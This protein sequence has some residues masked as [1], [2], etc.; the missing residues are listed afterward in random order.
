MKRPA[1]T[2]VAEVSA[3]GRGA[4]A[5]VRVWG[6]DA[7]NIASAAFRPVRDG[8]R[9]LAETPLNRLRVGRI[10]AGLGDEV[11]AVVVGLDP[12]EVEIQC[13]GGPVAVA[14][15]VGA[16]VDRGARRVGPKA[17][18]RHSTGSAIR[19]DASLALAD[20]PTLRV[21]EILLDQL[22]GALEAN[23]ARVVAALNEFDDPL[24]LS[25]L[26]GLIDRGK[27][28][29]RL[30]VGWRVVLAG[31]PNVGKSRLLN[32]L[33]GFDRAIVA[34]EPGT[35]RDVVTVASAMAAWPVE[36]ADTAGLR[37]TDDPIEREGVALA[38]AWQSAADLVVVVLD[39]SEP[40]TAEDWGIL[41][42]HPKALVVANKSDLP[43]AWDR[44]EEF[45]PR[46]V[47][48]ERGDGIEAFVGAIV[49]WLN[50]AVPP[51]G[52]G[53]PF[54]SVHVRRL[55]AIRA[56]VEAGDDARARRSLLRWLGSGGGDDRGEISR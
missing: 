1:V 32:A 48:A 5:T 41:A 45:A 17:W 4:V 9:T 54:R 39:R 37:G 10:G 26:D 34:P 51:V 15:V 11:V 18:A 13:H 52:S 3:S 53:V 27:F 8:G 22:E 38:Q 44:V 2:R 16:L 31:R 46:V 33:A 7:L 28:G 47:S 50:L 25:L 24:A 35:T 12:P 19:A 21:A 6:L 23:L 20:A 43:S 14:L 29:V 40:I 42:D 36:I 30:L 56:R 49:D 55:E